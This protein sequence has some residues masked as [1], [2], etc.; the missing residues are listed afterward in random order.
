MD[1]ARGLGCI[2][3]ALEALGGFVHGCT[4]GCFCFLVLNKDD[5]WLLGTEGIM[6]AQVGARKIGDI[7]SVP[8]RRWLDWSWPQRW[9]SGQGQD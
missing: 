1:G 5:F 8:K 6:V 4:S 7:S 2:L 3:C 9:G